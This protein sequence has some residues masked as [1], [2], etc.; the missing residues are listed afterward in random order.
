MLGRRVGRGE[1]YYL[2]TVDG[3]NEGGVEK[4]DQGCTRYRDK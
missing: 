1:D 4:E 2:T 3:E